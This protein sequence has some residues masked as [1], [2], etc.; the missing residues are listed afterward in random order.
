LKN[1]DAPLQLNV[2]R[3]SSDIYLISRVN[4]FLALSYTEKV[5]I[6][7][8]IEKRLRLELD[9]LYVAAQNINKVY[10]RNRDV[11]DAESK[12]RKIAFERKI[13]FD[14]K[15]YKLQAKLAWAT[16]HNLVQLAA[17]FKELIHMEEE[18]E[19]MKQNIAFKKQIIRLQSKF[20][21][22]TKQNKIQ[23]AARIEQL[24]EDL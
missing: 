14:F 7:D 16:E 22:A 17:H 1:G 15:L 19:S 8:F 13:A 9:R 6:Q 18:A 4:A 5:D 11:L 12:K 24:I 23:L 10:K 2:N 3:S 20:T 21:R